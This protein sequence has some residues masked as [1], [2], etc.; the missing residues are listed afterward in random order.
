MEKGRKRDGERK[1]KGWRKEGKGWE[2]KEKGWRKEGKGIGKGR[3]KQKKS[4]TRRY[5][6]VRPQGLEP[7]TH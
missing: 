6:F 2:R 3:K 1:E 7:W 4:D 5:R